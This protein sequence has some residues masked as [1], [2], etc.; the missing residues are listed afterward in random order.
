[1]YVQRSLYLV[2]GYMKNRICFF[3]ILLIIAVLYV[4]GCRRAGS[5]LVKEDVPANADAMVLLMGSFPERVMQAVDLYHE[6]RADRL[7]IVH[8][9]MGPYELLES[10]GADIISTT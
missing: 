10:K 8:E 1:M 5:W 6:G 3:G 7:I 9:S 4:G 2:P